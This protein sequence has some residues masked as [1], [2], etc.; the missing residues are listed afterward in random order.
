M[1][2]DI[3]NKRNQR[4]ADEI[5]AKREQELA[6]WEYNNGGTKPI[7]SPDA[8]TAEQQAMFVALG[9]QQKK[10]KQVDVDDDSLFPA[11]FFFLMCVMFLFLC[12]E[13]NS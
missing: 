2:I 1:M 6:L 7:S 4:I 10:E 12:R 3:D 11:V 13:M 8:Y 9:K 5:A